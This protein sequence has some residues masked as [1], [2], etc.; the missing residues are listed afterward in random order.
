MSVQLVNLLLPCSPRKT[1]TPAGMYVRLELMLYVYYCVGLH[2][3]RYILISPAHLSLCYRPTFSQASSLFDSLDPTQLNNYICDRTSLEVL[4]SS[5][6][7]P[8]P[9]QYIKTQDRNIHAL[10]EFEPTISVIKRQQTDALESTANGIG[11]VS[12]GESNYHIITEV[13][14]QTEISTSFSTQCK[15]YTYE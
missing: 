2:V 12:L 3:P 8:L 15:C 13:C 7:R 1:V 6:H 14:K 10:Q 4:I 5:S 11:R 9:S